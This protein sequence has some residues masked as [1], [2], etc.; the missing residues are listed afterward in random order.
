[1]AFWGK[2]LEIDQSTPSSVKPLAL[3]CYA[4]QGPFEKGE[5]ELLP[6]PSRRAGELLGVREFA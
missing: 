3:P 4:S 2:K 1:M 6:F 5:I